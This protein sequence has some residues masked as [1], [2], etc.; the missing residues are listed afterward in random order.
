MRHAGDR[1]EYFVDRIGDSLN[2]VSSYCAHPST[3]CEVRIRWDTDKP[4]YETQ[5][6]QGWVSG[7]LV[8]IEPVRVEALFDEPVDGIMPSDHN[9]LVVHYRLSWP[10]GAGEL[11]DSYRRHE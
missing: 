11:A 10:A 4:W 3:D 9:G 2:E 8:H 6:L 1:I 7:S 5:D